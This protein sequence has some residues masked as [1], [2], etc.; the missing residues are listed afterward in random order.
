MVGWYLTCPG[1]NGHDFIEFSFLSRELLP[2]YDDATYQ[3]LPL[4]MG[5]GDT[6]DMI[7]QYGTGPA[8]TAVQ[9]DHRVTRS[10]T[11]CRYYIMLRSDGL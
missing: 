4:R 9:V 3:N 11:M 7:R 10:L 8:T 2:D 6:L 5:I 1:D